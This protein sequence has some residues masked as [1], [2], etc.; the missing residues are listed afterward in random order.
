MPQQDNTA[1]TAST[2]TPTETSSEGVKQ[3]EPTVNNTELSP[4]DLS[5]KLMDYLSSNPEI[6][7][8]VKSEL[9]N[10]QEQ[11]ASATDEELKANIVSLINGLLNEN[12]I[13][14]S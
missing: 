4:E 2:D 6:S 7:P 9:E 5:G 10:L 13:T 11:L 8:E 3:A 12:K 1:S 14:L